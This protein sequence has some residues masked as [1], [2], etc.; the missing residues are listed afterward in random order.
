MAYIYRLLRAEYSN[1]LNNKCI[2]VGPENKN[3]IQRG[4]NFFA[5]DSI[6]AFPNF[7]DKLLKFVMK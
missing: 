4:D 3:I 1:R 6:I 5:D 7:F 2:G